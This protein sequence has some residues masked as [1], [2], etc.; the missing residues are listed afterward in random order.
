MKKGAG[1]IIIENGKILLVKAR[2]GSN[3]PTGTIAFPGGK[4]DPDETEEHAAAR[5]LTEETGLVA[6][7]LISYPGDYAEMLLD[8]KAGK[9]DYSFKTYLAEGYSGTLTGSVE[10]EPFWEDL[11]IARKTKL[12]GAGNELLENAIKFLNIT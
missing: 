3:Q 12:L 6:T 4:V 8:M 1:V 2:E 10:T 5:E 11:Q 9:D 7:K